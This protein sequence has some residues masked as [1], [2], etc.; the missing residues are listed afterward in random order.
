MR[1]SRILS[2]NKLLF[3]AV[4]LY[5]AAALIMLSHYPPLGVDEGWFGNPAYNLATKGFLGAT[6]MSG[7]YGTEHHTYWMPPFH[8]LVMAGVFKVFS[9]GWLQIRL[10][11]VVMGGIALVGTYMLGRCLFD[12]HKWVAPLAALLLSGEL[13]FLLSARWGRMEPTVVACAVWALFFLCKGHRRQSQERRVV[14]EATRPLPP[15]AS[16][17][18]PRWF[19]LGGLFGALAAL[20]HPNGAFFAPVLFLVTWFSPFSRPTPGAPALGAQASC[21]LPRDTWKNRV[22]RTAFLELGAALAFVPCLVYV[23]QAPADAVNQLHANGV[24]PRMFLSN[25]GRE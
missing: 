2:P 25:V 16:S 24:Q 9:F 7:F 5:L 23:A 6:L 21:L 19:L 13:M 15:G 12:K 10:L 8:L 20:S 3:A 18:N 1:L 11:S 4:C 22:L 17:Q 14:C